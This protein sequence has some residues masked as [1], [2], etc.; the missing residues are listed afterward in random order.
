M[1]GEEHAF[2]FLAAL[3]LGL[4]AV[5][6]LFDALFIDLFLLVVWRPPWLNLP[7]GQPTRESML[8]HI[9]L[10]FTAGW[11]FKIPRAIVGAVLSTMLGAASV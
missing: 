4:A 3:N 11:I 6:S 10:Q 9:K 7:E 8:R 5:L 1:S 2:L